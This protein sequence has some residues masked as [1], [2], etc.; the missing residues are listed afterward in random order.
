MKC[1]KLSTSLVYAPAQL[2]VFMTPLWPKSREKDLRKLPIIGNKI[3]QYV[4][5]RHLFDIWT[6]YTD[7][8]G[9]SVDL[10]TMSKSVDPDAGKDMRK[11][12]HTLPYLPY[13]YRRGGH[14]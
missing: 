12:I 1:A 10:T 14:I 4:G 13:C 5:T 3:V 11:R 2:I 9:I 7:R 6:D 8:N